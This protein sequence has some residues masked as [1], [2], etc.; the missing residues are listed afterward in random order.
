MFFLL[1]FEI[2]FI[3]ANN[4]DS[5]FVKKKSTYFPI[6]TFHKRNINI[7]GLSVGLLSLRDKPS[8]TNTNGIRLELIGIGLFAPLIPYSPV[9]Q[10]D[11]AFELEK[12]IEISERINGLSLSSTGTACDC[13]ING[14]SAGLIGQIQFKVNGI[15]ASGYLNFVQIHNGIQIAF[16]NETFKLRGLQL[17]VFNKS[18]QT[19]GFQIGLWNV[20][21][22]RALPFINWNFKKYNN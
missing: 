3:E 8:F 2:G 16:I 6:W 15:S 14:V 20:N 22:K 17:G 5:N 9:A 4:P 11:S 10:S 21:E 12:R 7:D 13:I 18:H 1:I 19:K